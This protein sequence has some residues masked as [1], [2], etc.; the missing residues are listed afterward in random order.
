MATRNSTS[1]IAVIG[2]GLLI[3]VAVVAVALRI[4]A[5]ADAPQPVATSAAKP[6]AGNR[7][8]AA[9]DLPAET[10]TAV[11]GGLEALRGRMEEFRENMEQMQDGFVDSVERF[12][13]REQS[14]DEA[15]AAR[16]AALERELAARDAQIAALEQ[17]L[18]T[19]LGG[20]MTEMQAMM[21]RQQP[22][23]PVGGGRSR[24]EPGP[25]GRI[26]FSGT[27]GAGGAAAALPE[28]LTAGLSGLPA[29]GLGIV[30]GSQPEEAAP[31]PVW[32]IP[33]DA[34]LVRSRTLT[35]LIGRVP[36]DGQVSAPLPFKI[37][38][39][40]DNL[41]AGGQ[42]LPEI[43][44][45]IWSGVAIGDAALECVTGRLVSVTFI[46]ADGTIST[47]PQNPGEG[48]RS[49]AWISDEQGYP[50][51]PGQF[52]SNT[53]KVL[54]QTFGAGF[55]AGAA[56][57]FAQAQQ[58]TVRTPE[59]GLS[60]TLTGSA[61]ELALGRGAAAGFGEWARIVAERA[62]DAFDAVVVPPGQTVTVHTSVLI[63]I[64]HDADGRALR[65]LALADGGRQ[66]PGG[67]D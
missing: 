62:R 15:E 53:G 33:R 34:V 65:H 49:I 41:L 16:S 29:D 13:S 36:V 4:L 64:D 46:F 9:A 43:A 3:L 40:S 60:S 10:L 55:A 28:R 63:P 23:Y 7:G 58:T 56:D 21:E 35:A 19:R 47:F 61:G 37:L 24:G 30:P 31:V 12:R 26:W 14:R 48:D 66:R 20:L 39:G 27:G 8:G 67:L 51:L 5:P 50:C 17:S 57:A 25:D 44:E 6:A 42:E 1:K 32:S 18:E 11:S 54:R 22:D 38:T 52:V 45:T 2:A 59:G